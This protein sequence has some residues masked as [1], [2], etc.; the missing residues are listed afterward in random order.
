MIE[1]FKKLVQGVLRTKSWLVL[2]MFLKNWNVY[3]E[4]VMKVN[5]PVNNVDIRYNK[6]Y[7]FPYQQGRLSTSSG[8]CKRIILE[9]GINTKP[10]R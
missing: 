5:K 6:G 4:T 3:I 7:I 2:T 10:I 9:D 8:F 1:I